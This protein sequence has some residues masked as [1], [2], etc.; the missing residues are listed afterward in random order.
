[1]SA[2]TC[3]IVLTI[4]LCCVGATESADKS[5]KLPSLSNY[6]FL[7]IK[8]RKDDDL[9]TGKTRCI[10]LYARSEP[11][12]A[13]FSKSTTKGLKPLLAKIEKVLPD[14][15]IR[16]VMNSLDTVEDS[17]IDAV[18]KQQ[19]LAFQ[20]F[21]FKRTA[22]VIP[23]KK[24]LDVIRRYK[25]KTENTTTIFVAKHRRNVLWKTEVDNDKLSDQ[26]DAIITQIETLIPKLK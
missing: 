7:K 13:I 24:P 11:V 4:M 26:T 2:R 6:I 1:M 12:I 22:I 18:L 3:C 15:D 5:T 17:E 21:D 16:V 8:G 10:S 25:L 23:R 19:T 9:P 14:S 20:D